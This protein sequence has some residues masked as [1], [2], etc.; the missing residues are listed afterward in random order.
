MTQKELR[1]KW[2]KALR[3]GE[4]KQG[5]LKLR[6]I[7]EGE[8]RFCCLGVLCDV[9]DKEKW[10]YGSNYTYFYDGSEGQPS[11]K[12]CDVVGF[13]HD[14]IITDLANMN[15]RDGCTFNEIADL[16]EKHP[17]RFFTDD[18]RKEVSE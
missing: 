12:I 11:P 9:L 6:F 4:Y 8:D 2:I 16:L 10:I 3:S 7:R 14:G 1:K 13:R 17:E 15:D 18:T 5:R